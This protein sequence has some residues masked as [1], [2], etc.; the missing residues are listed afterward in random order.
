LGGVYL[1]GTTD[2]D[3]DGVSAAG[4]YIAKYDIAGTNVWTRTVAANPSSVIF[5]DG[6]GNLYLAGGDSIAKYNDVGDPIWVRQLTMDDGSIP[7][8]RSISADSL[9][10]IYVAGQSSSGPNLEYR[11]AFVSKL[12]SDGNFYWTQLLE[13]AE[14]SIPPGYIQGAIVDVAADGRGNVYLSGATGDMN[15]RPDAF[16]AKFNDHPIPEPTSSVLVTLTLFLLIVGI[17]PHSSA[18][19]LG[20]P[21][22]GVSAHRVVPW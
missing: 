18:R 11:D 21:N 1:V 5:A 12:D 10:N 6:L 13:T 22:L 8:G 3:L 4:T 14:F 7:S 20:S 17:R 15:G 2:G 19:N 16:L 9:G